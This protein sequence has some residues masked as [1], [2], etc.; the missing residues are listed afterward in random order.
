MAGNNS[1]NIPTG[2]SA[3]DI[4]DQITRCISQAR[5]IADCIGN[6]PPDG[7]VS[8]EDDSIDG[9]AWAVKDLLAQAKEYLGALMEI[10]KEESAA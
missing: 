1:I 2:M 8:L 10:H 6:I 7:G 3:D 9:A 5:G 4:Y